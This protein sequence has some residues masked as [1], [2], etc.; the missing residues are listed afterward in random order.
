MYYPFSHVG[1]S[2]AI[3]TRSIRV[4]TQTR[5]FGLDYLKSRGEDWNLELQECDEGD[6]VGAFLRHTGMHTQL[7]VMLLRV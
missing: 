3:N 5:V 1:T 2:V 7:L 4:H 6:D